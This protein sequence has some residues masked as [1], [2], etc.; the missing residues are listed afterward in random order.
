MRLHPYAEER[1]KVGMMANTI[2]KTMCK[3]LKYWLLR[4]LIF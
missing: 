2:Y 1:A 3:Y 4:S